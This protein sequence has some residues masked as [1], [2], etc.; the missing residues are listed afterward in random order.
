M[1]IAQDGTLQVG[2]YEGA[3]PHIGEALLGPGGGEEMR[4]FQRGVPAG[5]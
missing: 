2:N 4:Q 1:R 5:L 3:I